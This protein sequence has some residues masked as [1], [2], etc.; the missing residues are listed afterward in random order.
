MKCNGWLADM[1]SGTVNQLVDCD[2]VI[3]SSVLWSVI[4]EKS[5]CGFSL[6]VDGTAERRFC[7]GSDHGKL[8][9]DSTTM[10][11]KCIQLVFGALIT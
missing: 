9:D 2:R 10:N 5:S 7:S 3:N 1:V 11:L 6:A 4:D 8:P